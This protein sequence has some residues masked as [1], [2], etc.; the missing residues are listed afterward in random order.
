LPLRLRLPPSAG[1][2]DGHLK[3]LPS[4]RSL[5]GHHFSAR[6]HIIPI[7]LPCVADDYFFVF[8]FIGCARPN[9]DPLALEV[10]HIYREGL[11]IHLYFLKFQSSFINGRLNLSTKNITIIGDMRE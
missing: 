9:Q 10:D 3:G 4:I 7:G 11:C 2:Y 8:A 6:N 1:G 5:L